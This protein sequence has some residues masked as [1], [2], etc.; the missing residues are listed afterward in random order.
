MIGQR[1][2]VSATVADFRQKTARFPQPAGMVRFMQPEGT[3]SRHYAF[4][5]EQPS[6]SLA[7]GQ[8]D[9]R[10]PWAQILGGATVALLGLLGWR[11][12]HH[13]P[14]LAA[15]YQWPYAIAAVA[16]LAWWLFAS[17]SFLGWLVVVLSVWG[18]LRF[19]VRSWKVRGPVAAPTAETSRDS[20]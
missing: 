17:P 6:L 1:L 10:M 3:V 15:G 20:E 14:L 18:A 12:R 13:Q 9:S 4:E 5:G 16:G 19:P 2:N 7:K 8:S 11:M